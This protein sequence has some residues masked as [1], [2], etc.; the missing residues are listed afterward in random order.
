MHQ[1]KCLGV[2]DPCISAEER[3]GGS[4]IVVFYPRQILQENEHAFAMRQLGLVII[5]ISPCT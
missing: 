3:R 5:R 2:M 1:W 4:S